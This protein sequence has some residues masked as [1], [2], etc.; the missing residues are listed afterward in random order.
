[1]LDGNRVHNR[2]GEPMLQDEP[3]KALLQEC[4]VLDTGTPIV[5]IGLLREVTNSVFVLADADMH[6]CRDGHANQ[7]VYLAETRRDG[8]TVNRREVI[9][10][11]SAVISVSRHSDVIGE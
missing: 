6:D 2:D 5:Y 10:M 4:V 8:V 1:M 3:L 7:E 11:R 9:V